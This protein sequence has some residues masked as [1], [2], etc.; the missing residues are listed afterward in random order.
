MISVL[1]AALVVAVGGVRRAC[2]LFGVSRAGH[3]RSSQPLLNVASR[4]RRRPVNALT[5]EQTAEVLEVLRSPEH[6]ELAPAQ[7][8]AR[9]LDAG[10]YLC[11]ISTMYRVLRAVGETG[12][13]RRQRTHPAKKK[14]EL[15]ATK[16]CQVWSWDIERHEA[17]SNRV[18]MKGHHRRSVAADRVK[19]RAV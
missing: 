5:D 18:V 12:E 16:P 4:P 19:L 9:L 11:S 17:L 6:C 3:Y 10:V 2:I 14:P 1:F 7:V 15:L 13:R 8:W